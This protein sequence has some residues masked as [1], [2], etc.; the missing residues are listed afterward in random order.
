MSLFYLAFCLGVPG[1][2]NL[3]S[4]P[5]PG[6]GRGD[7]GTPK[8]FRKIWCKMGLGGALGQRAHTGVQSLGHYLGKIMT[9]WNLIWDN[10][11]RA[12]S[13][14]TY[15]SPLSDLLLPGRRAAWVEGR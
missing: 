9:L 1:G 2:V 11:C 8:G 13:Y 7:F 3:V 5:D 6:G 10:P 15:Y 4:Q 14:S 12:H